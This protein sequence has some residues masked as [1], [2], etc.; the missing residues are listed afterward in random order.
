MTKNEI[1]EKT[2]STSNSIWYIYKM[3]RILI[4][5]SERKS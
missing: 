1:K 5:T 2:V 4:R 3:I